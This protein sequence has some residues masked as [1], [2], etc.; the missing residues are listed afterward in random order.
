MRYVRGSLASLIVFSSVAFSQSA[1]PI[2]FAVLNDGTMIEP[3]AYVSRGK[4]T[5]P[6][7]GGS[8]S[9][10]LANFNKTYY[11]VNKTY[12]LIFGASPD[13]TV[14]VT[15]APTGECSPNM[16]TVT[17]SSTRAKLKGFVM[18]LAT[19]SPPKTKGS[20]LRRL[21]T[22][23]ERAEVEALVKAEFSKKNLGDKPLKYHNL[24]AVDAEGN[25][26]AELVGSYW[27]DSSD[28][29]RALLFFISEKNSSGK[30]I[31]SYSEFRS[32]E[33]ANVMSGDITDVDK[34][35]Y[36]ELLLD[37]VD[38][39]GNGVADIFS[40]TRSF[41]GAAFAAYTRTGGKWVSIYENSNYHCAF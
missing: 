19:S 15:K 10:D 34:G 38:F 5:P 41:E 6:V 25:G 22:A 39:D 30:Y 31:L 11:P 18:A 26:N 23:E 16:A 14:K 27:V 33:A 2:V 28:K 20:G 32:I 12:T 29:S 21:P 13:G 35:V 3:V 36:H 9:T 24:T 7:G 37:L 8:S 4:L 17:T 40:Y 1:K